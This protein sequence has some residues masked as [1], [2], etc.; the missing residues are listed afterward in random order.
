MGSTKEGAAGAS[1]PLPRDDPGLHFSCPLTHW[2][3]LWVAREKCAWNVSRQA[4]EEDGALER[5]LDEGQNN[6]ANWLENDFEKDSKQRRRRRG[7]PN[8]AI[9]FRAL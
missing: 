7:S 8:F 6:T 1:D 9:R 2:E 4:K 3:C 5:P